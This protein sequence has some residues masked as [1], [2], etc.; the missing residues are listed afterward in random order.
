MFDDLSVL[1]SDGRVEQS[2]ESLVGAIEQDNILGKRSAQSRKLAVRH[3]AKLYV[4]DR[5]VPLYRAFV[6]L[7]SPPPHQV[8]TNLQTH[9]A[10]QPLL[11][12]R[13]L[14]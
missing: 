1:L 7:W 2:R 11:A 3:L 13:S 6:F 8:S 14:L 9:F 5:N 10:V 4:L 12:F